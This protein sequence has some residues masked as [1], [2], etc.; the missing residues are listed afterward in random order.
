MS[1]CSSQIC[2]TSSEEIS[3]GAIPDSTTMSKETDR[4]MP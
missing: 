3:E 4:N 1:P 2:L